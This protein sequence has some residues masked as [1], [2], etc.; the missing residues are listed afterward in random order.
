MDTEIAVQAALSKLGADYVWGATGPD[1]FDC[2]GL[3]QWSY[4]QAGIDMTRTTYTQILQGESVTG[5]PQRGD[6]VFPEA[7]HVVIALGGDQCVHAPETGDVVKISNYWTAPIAIRRFGPNSGTVGDTA[8]SGAYQAI[9]VG[10]QTIGDHMPTYQNAGSSGVQAQIDNLNSAVKSLTGAAGGVADV[11]QAAGSFF[12]ILTSPD[13]WARIL[14]T[15]GGVI[16][17]ILSVFILGKTF[18]DGIA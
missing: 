12:N 7:G 16:L 14:K 10:N 5:A 6:L 11:I 15:A 3:V 4:K 18:A 17:I 2:S 13:G 1:V 9:P 8:T